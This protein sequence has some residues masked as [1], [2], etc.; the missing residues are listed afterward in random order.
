MSDLFIN[1]R[2]GVRHLQIRLHSSP[3]I[4]FDIND[5]YIKNPPKKWFEIY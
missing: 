2:F 5:Y 4:S 3:Y 1:W